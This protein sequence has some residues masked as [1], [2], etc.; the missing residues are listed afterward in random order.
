MI[1]NK[2]DIR[3]AKHHLK[4]IQ[5]LKHTFTIHKNKDTYYKAPLYETTFFTRS[6]PFKCIRIAFYCCLLFLHVRP[7]ISRVSRVTLFHRYARYLTGM[8]YKNCIK[9]NI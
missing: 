6:V 3:I 5:Q 7:G 1:F 4:T 2:L 8:G 9:S